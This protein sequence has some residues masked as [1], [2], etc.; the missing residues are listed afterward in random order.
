MSYIPAHKNI[1][2]QSARQSTHPRIK[3]HTQY[4]MSYLFVGIAQGIL[5]GF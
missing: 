4:S 2:V 5:F 3:K 1:H